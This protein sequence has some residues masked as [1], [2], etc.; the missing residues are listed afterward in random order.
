M[1][2]KTDAKGNRI[3]AI[4]R[5]N[6]RKKTFVNLVGGGE[7]MKVDGSAGTLDEN[8]WDGEGAFW[9]DPTI[10]SK[11]AGA[12]RTGAFGWDT[13]ATAQNNEVKFTRS[14][15]YQPS[16]DS[17]EG[18][19]N[20]Q[21]LPP[22]VVIQARWELANSAKGNGV[23]LMDYLSSQDL[24]VWQHWSIPLAD[25]NLPAENVDEFRFRTLNAGGADY[26]LDDITLVSGAGGKT[27]RVAP[28][29]AKEWLVSSVTLVLV[30]PD[31]GWNSN[32]F[33]NIA[34]GL[35][36]GLTLRHR[37]LAGS[38]NF[39]KVVCKHNMEMFGQFDPVVD[40]AYN[41]NTRQ[42]SF[43]MRPEP[44]EIVLTANDVLEFLVKDDLTALT[45]LRAFAHVGVLVDA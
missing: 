37:D 28:A 4:G 16:S 35:A 34:G 36:N 38:S 10:G 13:G 18:W 2:Y 27:F 39:W 1:G 44:A 31:T 8:V 14:T 7:S 43:V 5:P 19:I 33:A 22:T 20:L 6:L 41:D 9:A 42:I 3:V 30:A 23:D 17:I 24:G 26:Y 15:P 21:A 11:T 25:F 29:G 40:T 32:A 12:A 45:N